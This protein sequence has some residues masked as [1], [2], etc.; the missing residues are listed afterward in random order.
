MF[1]AY[2]LRSRETDKLYKGHCSNLENRVAGHNS[3]NTKSTKNRGPWEV[4][5]FEQFNTREEAIQREKYFKTAAG[6]RFLSKI[7]NSQD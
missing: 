1:F 3:N 2:V 6:R 5:Y 4:V 7:L